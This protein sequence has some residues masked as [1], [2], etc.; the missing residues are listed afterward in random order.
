MMLCKHCSLPGSDGGI[1]VVDGHVGI[2]DLCAACAKTLEA[3]MAA[4][5]ALET[6]TAACE[7]LEAACEDEDHDHAPDEGH[8]DI[9]SGGASR[10]DVAGDRRD[11]LMAE[12]QGPSTLHCVEV[13]RLD[14]SK[15]Q[16]PVSFKAMDHPISP[17]FVT[18]RQ[19]LR[20]GRLE[21]CAAC[22]E[23]LQPGEKVT[24]VWCHNVFFPNCLVHTGCVDWSNLA[25]LARS[26]RDAYAVALRYA[27]WF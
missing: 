13:W 25:G 21:R 6:V 26:L 5:E 22:T 9:L 18:L 8:R 7:A 14:G 19:T 15:T 16:A 27:H 2:V 4:C 24:R 17:A 3:V 10:P 23:A 11:I 20:G 1:I 12:T